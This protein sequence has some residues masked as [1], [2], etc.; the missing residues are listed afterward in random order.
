M[1]N[2]TVTCGV[3]RP[4]WRRRGDPVEGLQGAWYNVEN[5]APGMILSGVC[6][7]Q[8]LYMYWTA[9]SPTAYFHEEHMELNGP[10]P[11]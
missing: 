2:A 5:G 9:R 8:N 1:V 3:H 6:A 10:G 4:N 7:S 11:D